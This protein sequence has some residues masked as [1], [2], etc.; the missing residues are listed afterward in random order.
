LFLVSP[1]SSSTYSTTTIISI[2]VIVTNQKEE[3]AETEMYSQNTHKQKLA[4]SLV[5]STKYQTLTLK[6]ALFTKVSK[7]VNFVAA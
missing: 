1:W 6:D 5:A 2:I 7:Q 4:K 3:K